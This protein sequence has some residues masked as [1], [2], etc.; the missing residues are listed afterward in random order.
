M[1]SS[2]TQEAPVV[3][4]TG[5]ARRIGAAIARLFHARGWR[6]AL[7]CNTSNKEA[8]VLGDAL[9]EERA[10][11]AWVLRA[12]LCDAEAVSRL[13]PETLALCGRLDV[14]VNNA[15][16]FLRTEDANS[17]AFQ[18]MFALHVTTPWT[19]AMA[20]RDALSRTKGAIINLTDIHAE[21]PLKEYGL[22]CQTKAALKMQTMALAKTLAP[23]IRVNAVAPG[24]IAW[25]EG[26]NALDEAKKAAI[27][28][29]TPLARHG[30]PQFIAEAVFM[31]ATNR[32]ITGQ[33]L[34]VDGGRSLG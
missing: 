16:R 4:I 31:M 7:H 13:I 3:L 23:D 11:S 29:K 24:A 20:A 5:A 12:D 10:A 6:V 14:L 28:A 1:K 21:K 15:S 2:N 18:E 17:K 9:C 32:F 33:S 30:D 26:D 19:L 25:P 8:E 22:Y 27:I 34:A